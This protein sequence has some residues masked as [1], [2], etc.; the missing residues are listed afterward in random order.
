MEG[1]GST[2]PLQNTG[3]ILNEVQIQATQP[4]IQ[5]GSD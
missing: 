4:D 3:G 2:L 5:T 1:R